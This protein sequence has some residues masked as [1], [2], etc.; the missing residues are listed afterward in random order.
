MFSASPVDTCSTGG[1]CQSAAVV[2]L[3]LVV[4]HSSAVKL[5]TAMK[6]A[7]QER[8]NEARQLEEAR[9]NQIAIQQQR[10][11]QYGA[12]PQMP[13][14]GGGYQGHYGPTM[15]YTSSQAGFVGHR[16]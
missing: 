12:Y 7:L 8:Q 5:V 1:S 11:Q 14:T 16:Y 2:E 9:R 3:F 15:S 6:K 10:Q 13:P 4:Q